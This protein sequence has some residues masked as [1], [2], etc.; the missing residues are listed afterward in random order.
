MNKSKK[1]NVT[2][3][4]LVTD[5]QWDAPEDIA[6][7]LPQSFEIDITPGKEYLLEDVNGCAEE[8]SDYITDQTGWCHTGFATEVVDVAA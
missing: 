2:K 4:I 8:I 7:D 3:R 6:A 5:I 1:P